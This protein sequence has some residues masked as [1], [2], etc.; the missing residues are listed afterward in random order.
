MLSSVD[1]RILSRR[2]RPKGIG[3]A[4]LFERLHDEIG[5]DAWIVGRVTGQEFAKGTS[6]PAS[7]ATVP[8]RENH[9][10]RTDAPAYGVVLDAAGKIVWGRADIGG[11]PIV[12][13]LTG[14]VS[15]AHLAGLRG[16]GVSCL[17]AGSKELDLAGLLETFRPRSRFRAH[18]G[19]SSPTCG[20]SAGWIPD[21]SD[22]RAFFGDRHGVRCRSPDAE[23]VAAS[24][25][26]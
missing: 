4:G 5:C 19:S 6:Y 21:R 17:F 18:A 22:N 13:V 7:P 10:V 16:D 12:A 9:F 26:E 1:G 14:Q 3:V 24:Y 2:W 25:E 11:D 20:S 15:D 8:A 23:G